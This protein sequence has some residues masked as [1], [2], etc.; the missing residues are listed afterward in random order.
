MHHSARDFSRAI[1]LKKRNELVEGDAMVMDKL[2]ILYPELVED[3]NFIID[4]RRKYKSFEPKYV[5]TVKIEKNEL[6]KYLLAG[7]K[8]AEKAYEV[9]LG[10]KLPKVNSLISE[11][12][13]KYRIDHYHGFWLSPE[14]KDLLLSLVLEGDKM[15]HFIYDL[16]EQKW[17]KES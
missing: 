16:K 13:M 7:E 17:K 11:L 6:G 3:Y 12:E 1:I 15:L 9:V 10:L 5:K 8:F 2:A 14:R 4:G